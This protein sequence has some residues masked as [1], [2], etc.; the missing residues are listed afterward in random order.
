MWWQGLLYAPCYK[1]KRAKNK[2]GA[3]D[4]SLLLAL[5]SLLSAPCSLLPANA[6]RRAPDLP[7][8]Q[9]IIHQVIYR[10]T[11]DLANTHFIAIGN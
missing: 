2:D 3:S 4:W 1:D 5:Y 10:G 6:I 7:L 9:M 11:N 8:T